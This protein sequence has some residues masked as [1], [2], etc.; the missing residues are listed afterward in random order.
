MNSNLE[1]LGIP[2]RL[3]L[4]VNLYQQTHGKS[5]SCIIA[6]DQ[7]INYFFKN[8]YLRNHGKGKKEYSGTRLE[9]KGPEIIKVYWLGRFKP[10]E[11]DY[12]AQGETKRLRLYKSGGILPLVF[13]TENSWTTRKINR[14][15][16]FS[17]PLFCDLGV[18]NMQLAKKIKAQLGE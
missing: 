10:E 4:V 2:E 9:V 11:L 18:P 17:K 8:N 6:P 13:A 3:K 15:E 1:N 16:R 14:I 7:T 12:L 5:P